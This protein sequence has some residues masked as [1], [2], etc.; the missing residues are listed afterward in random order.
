MQVAFFAD[1][2]YYR[3]A[4]GTTRY[5]GELVRHLS[6][7]PR[8]D[9]RLFSL[10]PQ[11]VIDRVARDRGY[12]PA[13]S[14]REAIP[15]PLRYL[16]WHT[17]GRSGPAAAVL[18]TADVVHTPVLL[19]PPRRSRPLVVSVL[20]LSFLLYPQFHGRWSRTTARMGLRRAV[21]EADALIAISAHTADDLVRFTGVDRRHVHVI[22]LAVDSRFAPIHDPSVPV[23]YGIDS[24]YLL[25]LGT[26]EPRKNL[27]VLLHAFARLEWP[28]VKLVLAGAKGWIF[29]EIFETVERLGLTSRV[30]FP[31]FVADADL[32]ALLNGAEVFVYPSEYE[33][34]GLP[35]LEA[36]SCGTPV[37]TTN[38][39][40]L[41]E[42]AGEAALLVPP[43][44]AEALH[45]ALRRL[46]SEPALREEMRGKGLERAARFSWTRTAQ[47]TADVYCQ[48]V[49]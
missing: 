18:D 11:D 44:D 48:V 4:A 27:K 47:E 12:P 46:L 23:R 24:R 30:V 40:S 21:R 5:A 25:Y 22:P 9:L 26:L 31:G 6:M 8:I 16:L 13:A 34:F 33:G 35:V 7:V 42:V 41:P 43:R 15:R 45:D 49:R 29:Q 1:L 36:M 17:L 32:P 3:I 19:V 38:V 2:L 28:G 37:V 10:Y 20:D 14:L 39:S